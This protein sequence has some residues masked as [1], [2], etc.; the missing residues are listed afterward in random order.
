MADIDDG[1]YMGDVR[2]NFMNVRLQALIPPYK[3]SPTLSIMDWNNF[4]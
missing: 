2:M 4:L 3:P 1:H